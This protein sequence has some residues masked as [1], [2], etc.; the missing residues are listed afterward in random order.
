MHPSLAIL[1]LLSGCTSPST[2]DVAIAAASSLTEVLHELER[3]FEAAHP[4]EVRLQFGGSQTLR[5]QIEHGA[6]VN[7]FLSANREHLQPLLA[8]GRIR[9]IEPLSTTELALIVPRHNPAG[10]HAFEDLPKATRLVIGA[11]TVPVGTYTRQ[12]LQRAARRPGF[13]RVRP[14]SE[15]TNVRL[16]RAKV[17]LGEA[18]AAFVYA[19]D[20]HEGV[21]RIAIPEELQVRATWAVGIFDA[22]P[23]T[24]AFLAYLRSDAGRAAF[25]RHGFDLP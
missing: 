1:A 20:V 12:L 19:T 11:A 7:M 6:P 4:H 2:G 9:R 8:A 24:E 25:R 16:V 13:E 18:D 3:S 17:E 5:M 22:E 15:E 10:I 14:V 23:G 21:K